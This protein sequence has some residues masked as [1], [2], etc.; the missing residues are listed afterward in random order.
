MEVKRDSSVW[1]KEHGGPAA[2]GWQ[3][4]YA[5]FT[6]GQSQAEALTR[7]IA[8]QRE[9]HTRVSFQDELRAI[10]RKYGVEFDE[11]YVWG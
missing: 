4:G 7:Y 9:H 2:F 11:R 3:D 5:A 8:G 10:L 1:M 6:I